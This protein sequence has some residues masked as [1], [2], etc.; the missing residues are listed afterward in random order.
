MQAVVNILQSC[1]REGEF[2]CFIIKQLILAKVIRKEISHPQVCPKM[3]SNAFFIYLYLTQT[4]LF[5]FQILLVLGTNLLVLH[6]NVYLNTGFVMERMTV[7]MDQMK[8]IV[9]VVSCF[10]LIQ[11]L[12][13]RYICS[14]ILEYINKTFLLC[15]LKIKFLY[16]FLSSYFYY[17]HDNLFSIFIYTV[18]ECLGF[19]PEY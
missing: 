7:E 10:F 5:G 2:S 12:S 18:V 13:V 14:T 1:H 17:F 3:V 4:F 9:F 8:V 15:Y 19:F 16:T 6:K 11:F